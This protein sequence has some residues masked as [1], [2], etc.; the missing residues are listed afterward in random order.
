[1]DEMKLDEIQSHIVHGWQ[2]KITNK[3][4]QQTMYYLSLEN[5]INEF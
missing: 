4:T 2:N 5:I 3:L 1:M